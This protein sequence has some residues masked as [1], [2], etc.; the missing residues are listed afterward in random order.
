MR[1]IRGLMRKT[2]SV[3]RSSFAVLGSAFA[4]LGSAFAV[5]ATVSLAAQ[6]VNWPLHSLDLA[7]SRFSPL[8]QITTANVA[9]LKVAWTFSTGVLNGHEGQP[10]VVD[11]TM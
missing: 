9:K 6:N 7:G 4:V 8:D 11:N 3:R 5:L 1:P 10:L 2:F